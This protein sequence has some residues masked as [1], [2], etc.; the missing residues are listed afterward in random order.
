MYLTITRFLSGFS[1]MALLSGCGGFSE[2]TLIEIQMYGV[3]R[4]PESA[5]GDRDPQF[6]S[7]EVQS[8]TLTSAEGDVVLLDEVETF[9]IV[10]RPQI[11]LSFKAD[12]LV[13]RVF[14]GMTVVFA[15]TVEGGDNDEPALSFTL[16]NPSLTLTQAIEIEDG[17]SKTYSIKANW[18]NTISAGTMT[19]PTLE[20]VA[21]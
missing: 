3:T 20:L 15:A 5:T 9:K 18:A 13:D 11:L 2:E 14:T 8:I 16:T 10:D 19:E 17:K 21:N 7:Y 1:L 4:A 6:Q 12:E